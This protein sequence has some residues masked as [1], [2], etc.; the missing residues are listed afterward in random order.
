MRRSVL[1]AIGVAIFLYSC[2]QSAET[3][4][5]EPGVDEFLSN[6]NHQFQQLLKVAS[7]AEWRL[8]TYIVDGDTTSRVA[9]E[10][11]NQAFYDFTGSEENINT[12]RK[13]LESDELTNLQQSQ[14][15]AV[16]FNAGANPS[17][18]GEIIS[19]KIKAEGIQTENLYK[20]NFQIDGESVTTN[21]ID[22]Q[23]RE[24]NDLEQRLKAWESSK[25]VGK[26]LKDGLE[27][28][29][30]LRNQS[31]QALGYDD[32]FAYQVSEY[33]MTADEMLETCQNLIAEIWPLFREL[34]TW[35]RYELAEKYNQPVP[36]LIPAHW[37]P[38]RWGQEW[39]NMVNVEGLDL[40]EVLSEKSAEWIVE[41]GERFYVS[42]GFDE[43]P[44]S[45]YDL[46]SLYPLPDDVDYR[47]NNH[48]SAWHMDN[49]EDVRSLMSVEPN[50][51][52]WETTLHELGHIYYY[53]SY[54]NDDVPIILREGSNR[55]YHEAIGS[56]L[57]L[58]SLQK[59]FLEGLGLMP[60]G[61]ETD[62]VQTL[63]KE[64][65]QYIVFMPFGAGVMTEFEHS[66]YSGN[67]SK[68]QYNQKWWDLKRKYQGIAPPA[69]RGEEYCDA[70]SKTHINDDAGQYYD[71]ALS[72]VLLFQFHDH[73]SNNILEQDP[74]ATN[75]YG[76]KDVG[77]FLHELMYPGATI[78]WRE[79]TRNM[80]GTDM[81]A[82]AMLNYFQPLMDYLK[83][84]NEGREHSL[85]ESPA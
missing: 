76:N 14:L 22:R 9:Y 58:A 20:F 16:L 61:I 39:T 57:G 12:A 5:E 40:D 36:D 49:A 78:D 10:E 43:L 33:G 31:V 29:Q 84:Q 82:A 63:L 35:A 53:M 55:A 11:S 28:L 73:I 8:N 83:E 68:D 67:L 56:M 77:K 18:A 69:N 25:E 17:T 13:Y 1:L 23:L 80:L 46:S 60:E 79:H 41:E 72:F 42:L 45:F 81:S 54:T 48:A 27:N 47:K 19:Q 7:E 52:W 75:Y 34:H 59:P 70:S 6:Y 85:P 21:E 26:T 3:K 38:N 44:Q 24:S 15:E 65:L 64:A 30:S 32:F 50:T 62:E 74:H 66:L 71:Y 2:N 37:L 51:D 4:T